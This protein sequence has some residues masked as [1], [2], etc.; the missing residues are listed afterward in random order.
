MTDRDLLKLCREAFEAIPIAANARKMLKK[1]DH[2]LGAY[3]GN[4]S[5][6]LALEMAKIISDRIG[7]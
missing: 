4:E 5:D 3:A 6:I 1:M 2:A 7:D